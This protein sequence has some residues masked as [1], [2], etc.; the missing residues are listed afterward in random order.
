MLEPWPFPDPKNV[1]VVTVR[2]A[3]VHGAPILLVVHSHADGTW[4][5]RTGG[6][7]NMAD[8]LLVTLSAVVAHD[9]SVAIL[10]DLPNGW[11]ASR[12]A[13]TAPWV[14]SKSPPEPN[15]ETEA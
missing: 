3:L 9:P 6:P 15:E 5:F 11:R 14:R 2:K 10:A 7:F 8:A 12:E 13:V 1:A 4:Q